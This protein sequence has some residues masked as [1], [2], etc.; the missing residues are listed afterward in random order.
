LGGNAFISAAI[1]EHHQQ[2]V[3]VDEGEGLG[4][5]EV[6]NIINERVGYRQKICRVAVNMQ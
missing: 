6:K 5:G 4:L 2:W 1:L 3:L